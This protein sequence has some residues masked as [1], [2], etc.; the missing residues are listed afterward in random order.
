MQCKHEG[1][2]SPAKGSSTQ[3]DTCAQ[4]RGGL[5][6]GE[7]IRNADNVVLVAYELPVHPL[8]QFLLIHGLASCIFN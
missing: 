5:V 8:I 3:H 7:S 1:V 4:E 2:S 6:E